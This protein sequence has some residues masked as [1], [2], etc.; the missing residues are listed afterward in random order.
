[1]D[2]VQPVVGVLG[3]PLARAVLAHRPQAFEKRRRQRDRDQRNQR[4]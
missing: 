3:E 1:L 2:A 4:T